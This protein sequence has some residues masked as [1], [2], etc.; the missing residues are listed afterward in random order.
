[1][2]K[3]SK[4]LLNVAIV[5]LLAVVAMLILTACNE[6]VPVSIAVTGTDEIYLDEFD[7]A[8]Y[9]I[10]V[11]YSDGTTQ[12]LPLTAQYLSADDQAKLTTAGK[13]TITVNYQD[14]TTTFTVRLNNREVLD[15]TFADATVVYDGQ[16]HSLQVTGLPDGATVTYDGNGQVN[17]GVYTVTAIVTLPDGQPQTLT[18]TLTITKAT[19]DISGITF[20][21]ETVTYDGQAHSLAI[22]GSLPQGATVTY[23]DNG[24][25]AVGTYTVIATITI[26]NYYDITLTATLT[27]V[28]AVG[29]EG[30]IYE[31]SGDCYKVVKYNGKSSDV[32][33]PSTYMGL[34]VTI[35]DANAFGDRS[36]ESVVIPNSVTSIEMSAFGGCRSLTTVTIGNG[37][38]FIGIQ[39]FAGCTSLTSI[40]LPDSVTYLDDRAF[41]SCVNLESV[42]LGN[43]VTSI[44][45]NAFYQCYN[46]M[47][48][49]MPDSLT[50]IGENAF[51]NC[52]SLTSITIPDNVTYIGNSAFCYCPNLETVYYGGTEEQWEQIDIG[53]YNNYSLTEATRYYYSESKPDPFVADMYWHWV[54]EIQ[55][56]WKEND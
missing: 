10:T 22:S 19:Y 18:A 26:P 6:V 54:D 55:T 28:E 24:Q 38:T 11:T 33:I 31:M 44:G 21:D 12:M 53:K 15:L 39:A 43:S 36:I 5:A 16:P 3:Q 20:A 49:T 41:A 35:I 29:T 1:M 8:D 17:A 48:I 42:S 40:T 27:I 14:L 7:Y 51:Y 46:I 56:V 32:I 45:N 9:T 2:N 30:L 37:V 34:P 47:S 4:I 13:H 50:S 23:T 25:T 52:S